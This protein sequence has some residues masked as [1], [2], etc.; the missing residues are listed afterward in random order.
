M[1]PSFCPISYQSEPQSGVNAAQ[2]AR[3]AVSPAAARILF[4]VV[5]PWTAKVWRGQVSAV[6]QGPVPVFQL[7]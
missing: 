4:I 2:P 6:L 1:R 7:E 3:I 5:L